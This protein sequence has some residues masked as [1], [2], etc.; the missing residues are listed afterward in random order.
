[1][2]E[3]AYPLCFMV[4]GLLLPSTFIYSAVFNGM[5]GS[6]K[7]KELSQEIE[8]LKLKY[9]IMGM[10]IDNSLKTLDD[11]ELSDGNRYRPVLD[12]DSIPASMRNMGSGGV[13]Q[14]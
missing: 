8:N 2:E 3:Q 6:P 7:E 13:E 4:S 14:V 12:M 11:L 1:M 5:F 9:S 10:N